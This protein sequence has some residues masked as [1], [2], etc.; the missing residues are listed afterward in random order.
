MLVSPCT[1]CDSRPA[2]QG[3]IICGPCSV[4]RERE[5]LSETMRNLETDQNRLD[6]LGHLDFVPEND[7]ERRLHQAALRKK[8]YGNGGY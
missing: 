6:R 4:E 3:F 8:N 2:L 5:A 7:A 1:Q